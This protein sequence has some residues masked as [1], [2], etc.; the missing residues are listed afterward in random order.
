MAETSVTRAS[1]AAAVSA[2]YRPAAP[3]PTTTICAAGIGRYG[4]RVAAP[5]WLRPEASF[6]HVIPGH[7]E[8]PERLHGLE[9]ALERHGWFGW[10]VR[11]SPQ[12]SREAL[13]AVHPEQHVAFIE[14]LCAA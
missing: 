9:G 7:P 13:L 5:L 10:D 8:R 6:G 2:V 14:R 11:S 12:A 1:C 3:A 4:I